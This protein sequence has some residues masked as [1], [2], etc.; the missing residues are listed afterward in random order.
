MPSSFTKLGKFSLTISLNIFSSPRLLSSSSGTPMI[1]IL[2]RFQLSHNSLKL[3]SCFL[4]VF[5][6]WFS[7]WLISS[8]LSSNSLIRSS[9]SPTLLFRPSSVFFISDM[10]F[11]IS[12]CWFFISRWFI[13]NISMSLLM[14]LMSLHMLLSFRNIRALNSS[15]V[16]L[17]NCTSFISSSVEVS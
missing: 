1:R 11:F 16:N 3:S 6:F 5:S 7:D 4:I 8:S 10:S 15:S 17:L 2:F 9:A 12:S 13:F 14:L